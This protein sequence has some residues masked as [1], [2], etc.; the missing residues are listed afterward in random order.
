VPQCLFPVA[1]LGFQLHQ[2][3]SQL[4]ATLRLLDPSV[5]IDAIPN[6]RIV[7]RVKL[8]GQG[9]LGRLIVG[10]LREAGTHLTTHASTTQVLAAGGHGEGATLAAVYGATSPT[11]HQYITLSTRRRKAKCRTCQRALR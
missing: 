4:R 6:K 3:G 5:D 7:K 1:E 8:F 2:F 10:V 11:C 9:E